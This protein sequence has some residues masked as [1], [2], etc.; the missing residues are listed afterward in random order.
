METEIHAYPLGQCV[1]GVGKLYAVGAWLI[2]RFLALSTF[3][4]INSRSQFLL[5]MHPYTFPK[6]QT[7]RPSQTAYFVAFGPHGPRTPANEPGHSLKVF[8]GVTALVAVA[9]GVFAFARSQGTSPFRSLDPY[10]IPI[11]RPK[12][13]GASRS[14]AMGPCL[15]RFVY[16]HMLMYSPLCSGSSS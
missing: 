12:A 14:W 1:F 6:P 4:P 16:G 5:S 15:E 11:L 7:N 9:Y 2:L 8:V 13:V 3:T 10:P